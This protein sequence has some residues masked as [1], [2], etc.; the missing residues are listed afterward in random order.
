MSRKLFPCLFLRTILPCLTEPML[1]LSAC[2]SVSYRPSLEGPYT[3][4]VS[5]AHDKSTTQ[6]HSAVERTLR[7]APPRQPKLDAL[8]APA[9]RPAPCT[10]AASILRPSLVAAPWA[11]VVV[12][13]AVP[14][15]SGLLSIKKILHVADSSKKG[16]IWRGSVFVF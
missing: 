5:V 8:R 16:P 15:Y 10:C 1:L 12:E 7:L 11:H 4:H 2:L 6:R 13:E 3:S 9:I 14:I